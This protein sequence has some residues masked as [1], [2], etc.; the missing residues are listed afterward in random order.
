MP[1]EPKSLLLIEDDA[2]L[3]ET[4]QDALE[5]AGYDVHCAANGVEGLKLFE[6]RS[7]ASVIL[8]DLLM[9]VMGGE[10]FL[11]ALAKR[12][13]RPTL[14]VVLMTAGHPPDTL[15]ALATDV[16]RKPF[17]L[18]E[19]LNLVARLAGPAPAGN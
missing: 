16:L 13:P 15:P 17:E 6:G 11:S 18:D 10:A 19:L 4:V 7:R 8:V 9:P 5:H 12:E 14:P 2:D 3:R 1:L